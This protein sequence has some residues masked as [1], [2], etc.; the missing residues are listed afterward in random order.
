MRARMTN[1]ADFSAGALM[2]VKAPMNHPPL[3]GRVQ[4]S[5]AQLLSCHPMFAD[6]QN[7][8]GRS[9]DLAERLCHRQRRKRSVPCGSVSLCHP[10][11]TKS[12]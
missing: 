2:Q 5:T 8:E 12:A 9:L 7:V 1:T 4:V 10:R 3:S 11:G 6:V